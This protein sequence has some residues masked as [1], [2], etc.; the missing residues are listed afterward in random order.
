MTP[1]VLSERSLEIAVI[2]LLIEDLGV[3]GLDV[4][5][6]VVLVGARVV[7]LRALKLLHPAFGH[8]WRSPS[9]TTIIPWLLLED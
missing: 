2:A 7:A 6:E 5:L 9:P 8:S 3:D 1:E 4:R